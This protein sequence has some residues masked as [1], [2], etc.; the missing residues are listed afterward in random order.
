[1]IQQILRQTDMSITRQHYIKT[2]T[3]QTTA[4]MGKLDAADAP[5]CT[6]RAL[7]QRRFKSK[8]VN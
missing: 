2:I 7:L 5:F 3:E 6:D 1:M 8:L 4:A